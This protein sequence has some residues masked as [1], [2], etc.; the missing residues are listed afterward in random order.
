MIDNKEKRFL[1]QI[2]DNQG[3]IH[4]VCRIYFEH[5]QDREDVFQ[6][7]MIHLWKS[8]DSFKGAS[9]FSTW[10]YRVCLNVALQYSNKRKKREQNSAVESEVQMEFMNTECNNELEEFLYKA[11]GKL[12]QV[13]KAIML[14]HFCL[15]YT[16]PSP[17]D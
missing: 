9:K 1:K 17:R 4:K 7:M 16:S 5:S 6:E 11:I 14:L 13:E 15:L 2:S 10:M 3:I 12:N 8:Y